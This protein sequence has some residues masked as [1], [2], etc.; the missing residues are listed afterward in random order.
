[1][2]CYAGSSLLLRSTPTPH[3]QIMKS[4]NQ[5]PGF[6]KCHVLLQNLPPPH[7]KIMIILSSLLC[8][9][10]DYENPS[11]AQEDSFQCIFPTL[12]SKGCRHPYSINPTI[13]DGEITAIWMFIYSSGWL[14]P[15]PALSR[16]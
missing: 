3:I 5:L 14:Y 9:P 4:T 15:S 6:L 16:I 13:R 8:L 7:T 10:L 2:V 12:H 1:M 11:N